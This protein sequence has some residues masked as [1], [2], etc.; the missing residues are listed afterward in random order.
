MSA[1]CRQ[2]SASAS[3]VLDL[4]RLALDASIRPSLAQG[5]CRVGVDIVYI[6]DVAESIER[7][8]ERY[9]NRVFTDQERA[10]CTGT[11]SVVANGLAARF[12]AKEAA[13]KVLQPI[14]AQ[15][16]WRSMEVVKQPS[17]A[18]ELEF[19]GR[20]AELAAASGLHSPAVS[21]SHEGDFAIAVVVVLTNESSHQD[22]P[23]P[24]RTG[25]AQPPTNT[26]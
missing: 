24:G 11:T 2:K 16:D 12:A 23:D 7:F 15:P 4:Q 9:L 1:P 19:R 25:P 10:S 5:G 20:A 6:H 26:D 17:G 3:D 13:V 22:L 14:G 8:G 21:L 18:C